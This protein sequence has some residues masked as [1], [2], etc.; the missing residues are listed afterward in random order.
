MRPLAAIGALALLAACSSVAEPLP[1]S[2]SPTPHP[3]SINGL[4]SR[5][6]H[7]VGSPVSVQ[8]QAEDEAKCK[9]IAGSALDNNEVRFGVQ[10]I[11]CLKAFGYQPDPPK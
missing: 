11:N 7:H 2:P 5:P 9:V 8:R 3:N 4:L 10:Y 6:W 1:P